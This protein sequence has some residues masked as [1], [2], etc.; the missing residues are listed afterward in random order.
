MLKHTVDA[1]EIL[2]FYH[3]KVLDAAE[4]LPGSN[5][6]QKAAQLRL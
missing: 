4:R 6:A 2:A 3:S 1:P 5:V